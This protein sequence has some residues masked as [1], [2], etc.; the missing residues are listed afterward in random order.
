MLRKRLLIVPLLAVLVAWSTSVSAL[1]IELALV[2]DGSGSISATD[3][4]K[5]IQGYRNAFSTG[6]FYDNF[7]AP[8]PF[9]TL[10]VSAYT[11]SGLVTQSIAW[12]AITNNSQATAFGDNFLTIVQPRNYTNTEGALRAATDGLLNNGINGDK[13]VIDISTDGQPTACAG[14]VDPSQRGCGSASSGTT[15]ATVAKSR[16]LAAATDARNSGI[17]V[18]ALGVGGFVQPSFLNELVAAGTGV[19]QAGFYL[20]ADTFDQF[21]STLQTKLGREVR[22]VPE[23]QVLLLMVGGVMGILALGRRRQQGQLLRPSNLM[24]SCQTDIA[25]NRSS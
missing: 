2:M 14:Y 5:Q 3:W 8:S 6:T 19:A 18:N 25:A 15:I 7:V 16:A 22:G 4:Q 10:Y 24:N 12:T 9:D 23:P 13:L 20:Q 11:F 1:S 17:F 21:A